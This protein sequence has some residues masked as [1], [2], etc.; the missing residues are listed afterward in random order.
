[1]GLSRFL[2]SHVDLLETVSTHNVTV[3]MNKIRPT[4]IG[5]NP[6]GQVTQTLSRFGGIES[7]VLVP[8]DLVALDGAVLS[9][10]TLADSAPRSPARAAIR[11]LV[12]SRLLPQPTRERSPLIG[13]FGRALA[14]D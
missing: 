12:A 11:E 14:R 7:P 1:V 8:H 6:N 2:R 4:A 10:R 9:G 3:V 13:R 5:M